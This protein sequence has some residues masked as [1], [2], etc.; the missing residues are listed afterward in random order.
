VKRARGSWF[1]RAPDHEPPRSTLVLTSSSVGPRLLD[2]STGQGSLGNAVTDPESVVYVVDDDASIRAGLDSLLR[3]AGLVV[4]CF[5]SASEFIARPPHDAPACLVLDVHLPE[6]SGLDLQRELAGRER[7]PIVFI[8]GHGDI[9]MSVRAMK[10]GAV[11][12]LPKPFRDKELLDGVERA[13]WKARTDWHA[14]LDMSNLRARFAS[15]TPRERQVLAHV[16]SGMLNKQIA[17]ALGI[18]EVTVKQHRGHVMQKL[19]AR[20]LAELV[21]MAGRIAVG[22]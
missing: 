17:S 2:G 3:S 4:Q 8:T 22:H 18:S 14:R 9:P 6:G 1:E 12:F 5:A 16:V 13:L 19:N 20:S 7:L 15:L 21:R 11:E 10:A